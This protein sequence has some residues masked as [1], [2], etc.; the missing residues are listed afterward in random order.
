MAGLL[1]RRRLIVTFF[2]APIAV[3]LV[4]FIYW[5]AH[6]Y[7]D[8]LPATDPIHTELTSS[9]NPDH[10]RLFVLGDSG[11]DAREQKW[12]AMSMEAECERLG[13]IDGI[14]LLGD[15]FYQSGV[16]GIQDP[17][18]Q[19]TMFGVYQG[20]CL[21]QAPI[22]PVL[23]NHDY[24]GDKDAQIM[25]SHEEPRWK[26]PHNFY[27]VSF[28]NI[29]QWVAIDT[30]SMTMCGAKDRCLMDFLRERMAKRSDYGWTLVYGHHPLVHSSSV[31]NEFWDPKQLKRVVLLRPLLSD[32]NTIYLAGH[33]HALEYVEESGRLFPVKQFVSGGGGATLYPIDESLPKTEFVKSSYGFLDLNISANELTARFID[34]QSAV[35]FEKTLKHPH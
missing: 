26:L 22:Y 14:L 7:W 4:G 8:S 23:G 15:N 21:S 3:G 12:V 34:D 35:L 24:R 11:S 18:W 28:Q 10:I 13:G 17:R 5:C 6:G 2:A 27:S 1:T 30:N 20:A 31:H 19:S 32:V 16:T 29:V 25:K 9:K 33:V